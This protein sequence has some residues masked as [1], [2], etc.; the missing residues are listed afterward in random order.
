MKSAKIAL[1]AFVSL[2][3]CAGTV[4]ANADSPAEETSPGITA[5][6][7]KRL[8]VDGNGAKQSSLPPIPMWSWQNAKP[9]PI[10]RSR[11]KP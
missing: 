8:I 6:L 3:F 11:E 9:Q 4:F 2:S 1:A 7:K 5:P 10:L